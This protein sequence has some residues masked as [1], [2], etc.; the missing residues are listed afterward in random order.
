M[1]EEFKPNKIATNGWE[2]WSKHVIT[3]LERLNNCY[4]KLDDKIDKLVVDVAMLKVKAGA[5]GGVTGLIVALSSFFIS[6]A[7]EK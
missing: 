4:E 5:W 7:L 1:P 6:K 2:V 3:E